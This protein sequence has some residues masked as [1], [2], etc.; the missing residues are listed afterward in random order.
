MKWLWPRVLGLPLFAI[1]VLAFTRG[2]RWWDLVYVLTAA[3]LV[4]QAAWETYGYL[5]RRSANRSANPS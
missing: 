2:G 1:I 5:R 3:M 4:G